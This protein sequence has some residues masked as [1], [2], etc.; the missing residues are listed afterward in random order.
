MKFVHIADMHFDTPFL[1][2]NNKAG[3]G[4]IRRLEQREVLKKIIDYIK[5]N[6]IEYL[7]ISGDLYENEYIRSSTIEYINNLFKEINNTKIYIAP[8]NHDPFIKNS[9]YN[10]F[11][12]NDNVYIFTRELG[13]YENTDATIYGFGFDDFYIDKF[14][15]NNINIEKDKLNILL[16]H[17]NLDGSQKDLREYNPVASKDLKQLGFEYIALG[18]IHKPYYNEYKENK[19]CYPG[20]TISLGFDEPGEHGMLVRRNN[21]R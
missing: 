19:M 4:E 9:Y 15:L 14:D 3:L 21:K 8:G 7:F 11:N 6:N 5:I 10:K 1:T 13:K 2:L 20:A 12:W 16:M 18:H 17:G